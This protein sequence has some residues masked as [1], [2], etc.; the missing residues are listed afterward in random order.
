M[1]F[2]NVTKIKGYIDKSNISMLVP[3]RLSLSTSN[4]KYKYQNL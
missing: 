2:A 1:V 4:L 3:F